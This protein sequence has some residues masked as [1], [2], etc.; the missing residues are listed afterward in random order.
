MPTET[1]PKE[2]GTR[3][4]MLEVNK[5]IEWINFE[6]RSSIVAGN[7]NHAHLLSKKKCLYS[8]HRFAVRKTYSDISTSKLHDFHF[9]MTRFCPHYFEIFHIFKNLRF[10]DFKFLSKNSR[11]YDLDN[12]GEIVL[13]WNENHRV[14]RIATEIHKSPVFQR[15]PE[16]LQYRFFSPYFFFYKLI[17]TG[18]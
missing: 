4:R 6:T 11:F 13:I 18:G 5:N 17:Y 9:K 2:T 10:C 14:L 12:R 8:K 15:K 1:N 3:N 16:P 7:K